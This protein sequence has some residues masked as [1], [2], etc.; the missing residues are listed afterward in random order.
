MSAQT[1]NWKTLDG[2]FNIGDG[3]SESSSVRPSPSTEPSNGDTGGMTGNGA[4]PHTS[5]AKSA[6]NP[7]PMHE[8]SQNPPMPRPNELSNPGFDTQATPEDALGDRV[9]Q[10]ETLLAGRK[11]VQ[12]AT[13]TQDVETTDSLPF[14][15]SPLSEPNTDPPNRTQSLYSKL[16]ALKTSSSTFSHSRSPSSFTIN[17]TP[18][19]AESEG[20]VIPPNTESNEPYFP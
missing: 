9:G 2:L 3:V 19:Y 20:P 18:S 5:P 4:L 6:L 13:D 15:S 7:G 8:A 17:N 12:F 1:R 10:T 11:N 14:Q 16:K